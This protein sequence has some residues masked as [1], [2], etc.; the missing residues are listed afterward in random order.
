MKKLAIIL[1]LAIGLSLPANILADT[2]STTTSVAVGGGSGGVFTNSPPSSMAAPFSRS[3][4]AAFADAA[5][6]MANMSKSSGSSVANPANTSWAEFHNT[7]IG[8]LQ[9]WQSNVNL[10]VDVLKASDPVYTYGS[11]LDARNQTLY[12]GG[13]SALPVKVGG[14]WQYGV[15][16]IKMHLAEWVPLPFPG[17]ISAYFIIR[18]SSGNI[19][20]YRNMNASDGEIYFAS[21]LAGWGTEFVVNWIDADG[22]FRQTAYSAA[23]NGAMLVPITLAGQTPTG[24]ENQIH[25]NDS[26]VPAGQTFTVSQPVQYS[27][28]GM[29]SPA[30]AQVKINAANRVVSLTANAFSTDSPFRPAKKALKFTIYT[31]LDGQITNTVSVD[32]VNGVLNVIMPIGKYL[33]VPVY[34]VDIFKGVTLPPYQYNGNGGGA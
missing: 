10:S 15:S 34:E 23:N 20:D 24:I 6:A 7:D 12:W 27:D 19:I 9:D 30:V 17:A 18:D 21:D 8:V 16:P 3:N 31:V 1:A 13:S 28:S 11:V 32:A 22:N 33:F 26:L 5:A 29:S 25:V 4:L 2:T 14:V